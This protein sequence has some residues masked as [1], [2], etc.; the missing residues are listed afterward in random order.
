M[1]R[2]SLLV[3]LFIPILLVVA[4]CDSV[5]GLSEDDRV[6]TR[7]AEIVK[8][9]AD[10]KL[11]V[12]KGV[13]D[14]ATVDAA[15]VTPTNPPATSTTAPLPTENTLPTPT[16]DITV[17]VTETDQGD[18][19][20][21][22]QPTQTLFPLIK[23]GAP[24]DRQ[25]VEG[26]IF[27]PAGLQI[28]SD[29]A[30]YGQRISFM[31]L[32][33]FDTAAGSQEGDGVDTVTFTITNASGAVVHRLVESTSPYCA[34]G[35]DSPCAE[36]DFAANGNKWPSGATAGS[37]KHNAQIEAT[38]TNSGRFSIWT[39][40]FELDLGDGGGA[41][42]A[43]PTL[44]PLVKQ[45]APGDRQGIEGDV[46]ALQGLQISADPAVYGHQISFLVNGVFDKNV[47]NYEG[48]GV[49]TVT[50]TVFDSN[51]N[52]VLKTVDATPLYCAFGGDKSCV[53]WDFSKNNNAWPNGALA[54]SGFHSA[55][56]EANGADSNRFS[57]WVYDFSLKLT[58]TEQPTLTPTQQT[59]TTP[60]TQRV[61][62]TGI[63]LSGDRYAVE[64]VAS[65][66]QPALPGMHM[67][68][69]FDTVSSE[70]AGA[71]GGGPWQIYPNMSGGSASSPMMLY[72]VADRPAG[73]NQMCVLVANPNHSVN[74]GTGNCY[75]LP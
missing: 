17:Q 37:G 56:I 73:A 35:G 71:P 36:W 8:A 69:Y 67:H 59:D 72:G 61:T 24:G 46:F 57:M 16:P 1:K 58:D 28:S 4:A 22:P 18:N 52:E 74:Q 39:Y 62:I 23:Q 66:Y 6:E 32:G 70:Q 41:V 26:N 51:G 31:A 7:A 43:T 15:N 21:N 42:Q 64:F 53:I 65:G 54:K 19:S 25:G 9:T 12:D 29:P 20:G 60:E 14:K 50:F 55:K 45:G 63:Q 44:F 40:D 2:S 49:S 34:F 33:V 13:S 11:A 38:G 3:L 68:F 75:P 5:N 30:I 27:A 47:G 10:F 48:D